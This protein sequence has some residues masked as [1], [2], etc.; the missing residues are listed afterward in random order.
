MSQSQDHESECLLCF[1]DARRSGTLSLTSTDGSYLHQLWAEREV[2]TKFW[3]NQDSDL[4]TLEYIVIF[5]Y[6]ILLREF[7]NIPNIG[8]A[9][10]IRFGFCYCTSKAQKQLLA[11]HYIQ[12]AERA[13]L[14]QIARAWKADDL[15][16]L[17]ASKINRH[18]ISHFSWDL[19]SST[20]TRNDR[21]LPPHIRSFT[22]SERVCSMSG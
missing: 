17:M 18:V 7:N 2:E 13:S 5:L 10:W 15:H 11:Q 21:N 16:E 1:L 4:S 3:I 20:I 12:L 14:S 22:H 6:R 19:S 8:D 9:E